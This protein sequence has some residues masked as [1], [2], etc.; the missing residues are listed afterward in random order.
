MRTCA[1]LSGAVFTG[2]GLRR[3]DSAS[4]RRVVAELLLVEL[5]ADQHLEMRA[6]DGG[7]DRRIGHR[8]DR[9]LRVAGPALAS[10][11]VADVVGQSGRRAQH[12]GAGG[13]RRAG[14]VLTILEAQ[15]D[16]ADALGDDVAV[17]LNDGG[18]IR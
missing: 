3:G 15:A 14:P 8:V 17:A 12:L 16:A 10:D 13:A 11:L 6:L 4:A 18:E 9:R 7:A 1:S 2:P 5:E